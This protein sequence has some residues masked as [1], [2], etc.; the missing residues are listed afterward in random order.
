M[1]NNIADEMNTI[2]NQINNRFSNQGVVI[3]AQCRVELQGRFFLL[4]E[5]EAGSGMNEIERVIII[6]ISRALFNALQGR[7]ELCTVRNTLPTVPAGRTLDLL[8][9]F[10]IGNVAYIVFEI[11]GMNMRDMLV[12][13]AS[14]LCTII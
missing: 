3:A 1:F 13:V 10:V 2:N 7:V 4:L 9:T 11:E 8:C 12:I 6:E 5:L 14:P